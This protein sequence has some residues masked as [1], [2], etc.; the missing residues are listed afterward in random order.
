MEYAVGDLEAAAHL[1]RN[2]LAASPDDASLHFDLALTSWESGE[3]GGVVEEFLRAHALRPALSEALFNAAMASAASG[4]VGKA[5]RLLARCVLSDPS[6]LPECIFALPR[7]LARRGSPARRS[8]WAIPTR[9]HPSV[10]DA[11]AFGF[12]KSGDF[13][14]AEQSCRRA[15]EREPTAQRRVALGMILFRL[16]KMADAQV[17]FEE[18]LRENPSLYQGEEQLAFV[19]EHDGRL[20][21]ARQHYCNAAALDP[22]P[23]YPYSRLLNLDNV[24]GHFDDADAHA[25]AL[26][27]ALRTLGKDDVHWEPLSTIAYRAIFWPIPAL[28]YRALTGEIDR[29]LS[30]TSRRRGAPMATKR[31][32][33]REESRL[34]VGYLSSCFRDHPIGQITAGLFAAHDRKRFEVHVLYA[35]RDST[36]YTRT[37]ARGAEH[38][39]RIDGKIVDMAEKIR[40]LDLDVL[41]YLDGYMSHTLMQVVALRPAATQVFWTGHAGG[42]E[43]SAIDYLIADR[44]VIPPGEEGQYTARVIR[45]EGTFA[46]ATPHPIGPPVTRTEA[47]LPAEG[48]VFCVFNNPEKI[49]RTVFDAWMRILGAVEESFLWMTASISPEYAAN[50]RQQA[51]RRGVSGDRLIFATRVKDKAAYFARLSHSGLY[52]DTLLLNGATMALDAMWVG[53]PVLTVRGDRFGSRIATSFLHAAGM[54]ELVCP[55]LADYEARAIAL[56]RDPFRLAAIRKRLR[57]NVK[58][59]ELFDIGIFCRRLERVIEQIVVDAC[60]TDSA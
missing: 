34:R 6:L 54:D 35:H 33:P 37:I 58:E 16:R 48:F 38:F 51:E 44:I 21:E 29:Q 59:G 40:D 42:L 26:Y 22:V 14:S 13:D 3:S 53:V 50:V 17:Q 25:R 9:D 49:D 52:L 12:L 32:L 15:L 55:S 57:N 24:E 30:E 4:S 11:I 36:E 19:L 45:L 43:I 28:E 2:A 27:K 39:H 56:A 8:A 20:A 41:V 7:V 5:L 1:L 31:R 46:P 18:A 60:R 47:G 23:A 10:H